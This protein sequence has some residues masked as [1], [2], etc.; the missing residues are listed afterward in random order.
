[1]NRKKI[2]NYIIGV[3]DKMDVSGENG[4]IYRKLFK[5]MNNN[6]FED[7]ISKIGGEY[8]IA[9]TAPNVT[10]KLDLEHFKK[11]AK[12]LDVKTFERLVMVESGV[13]TLSPNE[14]NILKLVVRRSAQHATSKINLPKDNRTRN[15]LTGQVTNKSKAFGVSMPESLI[16]AAYGLDDT[17]AEF[18]SIRGGDTKAMEQLDAM[19][20]DRGE[21]S[22]KE[23]K[24]YMTK[25]R[26]F[27]TLT[28]YFRGMHLK[29][30]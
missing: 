30:K 12:E 28:Q 10:K 15:S 16:L 7:W 8:H 4:D 24:P 27:K 19:L 25:T 29:L 5:S 13:R 22:I 1:M 3:M 26:G 20:L 17:L 21:A 9:F 18:T 11:V 14:Y 6:E 23:L 2:E